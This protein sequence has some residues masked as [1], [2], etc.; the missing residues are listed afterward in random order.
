MSFYFIQKFNATSSWNG[1]HWVNQ[2]SKLR[3]FWFSLGKNQSNF[4]T[5]I[6]GDT[7]VCNFQKEAVALKAEE[8]LSYTCFAGFKSFF[9]ASSAYAVKQNYKSPPC[10]HI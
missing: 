5:I 7:K 10:V 3:G 6:Y 8:T 2:S 4:A 9:Q 1:A